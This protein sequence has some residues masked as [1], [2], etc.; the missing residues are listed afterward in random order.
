MV[1]CDYC[2]D[3]ASMK[4][5]VTFLSGRKKMAFACNPCWG[6]QVE[7]EL[8]TSQSK[9]ALILCEVITDRN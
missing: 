5:T 6:K 2:K 7:D 8:K 3:Y 4:I 1:K 9:I